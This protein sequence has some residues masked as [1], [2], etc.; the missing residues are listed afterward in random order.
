LET[1]VS[2]KHAASII[3]VEGS[4]PSLSHSTVKMEAAVFRNAGTGLQHQTMRTPRKL[5][6]EQAFKY[7]V[8]PAKVFTSIEV[9]LYR[10]SH[11][12]LKTR[13][14]FFSNEG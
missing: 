9:L 5:P 7:T 8:F 14:I 3:R 12:I 4:G 1:D 2:Q 11:Y 10:F 13:G 6:P